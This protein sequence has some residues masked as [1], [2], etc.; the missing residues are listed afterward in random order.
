MSSACVAFLQRFRHFFA[1]FSRGCSPMSDGQE[2][3]RGRKISEKLPNLPPAPASSLLSILAGSKVVPALEAVVG[4]RVRP[5]WRE[6]CLLP[7]N[8]PQCTALHNTCQT[9]LQPR[10]YMTMHLTPKAHSIA[11][12][13]VTQCNIRPPPFQLHLAHTMQC[14]NIFSLHSWSSER[15]HPISSNTC[16]HFNPPTQ[17]GLP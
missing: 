13:F 12:T 8:R 3:T 10:Y 4:L 14:D 16:K 6:R 9:T 17:N 5:D 15:C 11:P 1:I 7:L 2:A